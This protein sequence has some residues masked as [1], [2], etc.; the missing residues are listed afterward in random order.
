VPPTN[1]EKLIDL[2]AIPPGRRIGADGATLDIIRQGIKKLTTESAVQP[3]C[4]PLQTEFTKKLQAANNAVR[5]GGH[6]SNF[7][8]I[9]GNFINASLAFV[10]CIKSPP[11]AP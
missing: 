9:W 8:L 6:P 10:E 2:L 5:G 7:G 4:L 11:D 1:L 3:R